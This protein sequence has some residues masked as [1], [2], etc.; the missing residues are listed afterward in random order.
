[1]HKLSLRVVK[2][3]PVLNLEEEL[4]DR[5]F[6][7]VQEKKNAIDFIMGGGDGWKDA[8]IIS[9]VQED[10]DLKVLKIRLLDAPALHTEVYE[11]KLS[12]DNSHLVI[13]AKIYKVYRIE[14]KDDDKDVKSKYLYENALKEVSQAIEEF[15]NHSMMLFA[16]EEN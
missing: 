15:N 16:S 12:L 14:G 13:I 8:P 11:S 7:P 5:D 2:G 9:G 1:M 10:E 3:L 6:A 4:S